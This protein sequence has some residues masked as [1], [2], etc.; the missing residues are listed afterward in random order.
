MKD[1]CLLVTGRVDE[2]GIGAKGGHQD[3]QLPLADDGPSLCRAVVWCRW[4]P[5]SL[6]SLESPCPLPRV[7]HSQLGLSQHKG[8]LPLVLQPQGISY[9]VAFRAYSL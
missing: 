9:L 3:W 7:N 6:L 1:P 5:V 4:N 8:R 2:K